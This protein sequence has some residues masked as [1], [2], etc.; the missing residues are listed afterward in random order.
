MYYK[1]VNCTSLLLRASSF[2]SD[3][4]KMMWLRNL[5]VTRYPATLL[6]VF[7]SHY[8][9]ARRLTPSLFNTEVQVAVRQCERSLIFYIVC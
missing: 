3:S 9:I 7:L 2:D 8:H 6:K 5:E 4:T 1:V